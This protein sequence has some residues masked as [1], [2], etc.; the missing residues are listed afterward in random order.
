MQPL[1]I[2]RIFMYLYFV[3]I[4]VVL[5]NGFTKEEKKSYP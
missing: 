4:N 2:D 1:L 3:D 5:K